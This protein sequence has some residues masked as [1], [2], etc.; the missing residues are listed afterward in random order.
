[1]NNTGTDEKTNERRNATFK[2]Q[3]QQALRQP[4]RHMGCQPTVATTVGK[5]TG[6]SPPPSH[7]RLSRVQVVENTTRRN[8]DFV[9][10]IYS[11]MHYCIPAVD[12][13]FEFSGPKRGTA[14]I[15]YI[16]EK[17]I[18]STTIHQ[19]RSSCPGYGASP[20]AIDKM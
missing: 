2:P 15:L 18:P 13:A 11:L 3:R 17:Q 16:V 20:T 9:Y 8:L 6:T 1:M 5:N 7:D 12:K 4:Q 19:Q 10:E 14:T